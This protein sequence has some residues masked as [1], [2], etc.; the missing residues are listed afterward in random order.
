MEPG[1][2]ACCQHALQLASLLVHYKL[3]KDD[4][5]QRHAPYLGEQVVDHMCANVV[6]DLV[7]GPV[8]TVNGGQATAQVAPLL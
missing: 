3:N 2:Q 7:E 5:R 4:T 1:K 8:V 6:L